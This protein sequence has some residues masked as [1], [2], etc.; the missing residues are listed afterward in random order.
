MNQSH[1]WLNGCLSFFCSVLRKDVVERG[2][3]KR[4]SMPG[5]PS[6]LRSAKNCCPQSL[7]LNP[8]RGATH[9]VSI[10]LRFMIDFPP[11]ISL[12]NDIS[13]VRRRSDHLNAP[14]VRQHRTPA[15]I[16]SVMGTCLL[17][18]HSSNFLIN[19]MSGHLAGCGPWARLSPLFHLVPR[20]RWLRS[21][22]R[23]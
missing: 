8:V 12:P 14:C 13:R 1:T 3:N 18:Q 6:D 2:S 7:P 22:L 17:Q 4:K 20:R 5:I 19:T 21:W 11:I 9:G 15:T 10:D 16:R 23:S